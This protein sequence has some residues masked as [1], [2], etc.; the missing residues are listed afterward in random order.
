M[1]RILISQNEENDGTDYVIVDG[2]LIEDKDLCLQYYREVRK[3]DI[4]KQNFKN[5]FLELKSSNNKI[6]LKSH[7]SDKDDANR[8]IYYTYLIENNDNLE[9]ILT[10]LEEDSEIINRKI[11]KEKTLAVIQK[12]KTDKKLRLKLNQILFVLVA[13]GIAYIVINALR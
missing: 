9:T 4:W 1:K 7:Y 12:I 3:S 5:D 2:E 11:D 8:N 6:F 10:Q 13:V